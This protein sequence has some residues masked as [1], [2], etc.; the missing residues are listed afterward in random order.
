MQKQKVFE[1]WPQTAVV[2][3]L[4]RERPETDAA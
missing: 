4:G 3:D 1:I 2:S